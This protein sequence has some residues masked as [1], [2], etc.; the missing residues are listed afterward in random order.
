MTSEREGIAETY[1]WVFNGEGSR[2]PSAVFAS[3]EDAERWIAAS[4]VS[5]V[6]TAY[7]LGESAYDWAVRK[8]YFSPKRDAQRTAA[9][10]Q[11]FTSASQE[12]ENFA[13]G[14]SEAESRSGPTSP[15]KQR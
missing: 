15:H 5:G 2:F 4:G 6:L 1:V 8:G 11:K 3:K 12:H 13:R 14:G 10:V 9:F 7:P